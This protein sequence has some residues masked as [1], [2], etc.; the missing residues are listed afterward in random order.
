[1]DDL[2]GVGGLGDLEGLW[3]FGRS[4]M[5]GMFGVCGKFGMFGR[6]LEEVGSTGA[7]LLNGLF[8]IRCPKNNKAVFRPKDQSHGQYKLLPNMPA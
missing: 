2:G 1:M 7:A 4:G 8:E 6:L 3:R 5:F